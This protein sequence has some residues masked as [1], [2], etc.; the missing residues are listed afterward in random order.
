MN[1]KLLVLL[2]TFALFGACKHDAER[3]EGFGGQEIRIRYEVNQPGEVSRSGVTT[4][5]EGDVVHLYIAEREEEEAPVLPAQEDFNKMQCSADGSLRFEDGESHPYPENPI[6]LYAYYQKEMTEQAADVTAIPVQVYADQSA[7]GDEWRSDFLYAVAANGYRNQQEPITMTFK[8]QFSRVKFTITTDTPSEL[9]LS[10]LSAVEI[11][12]LVMDGK[13]NL[14]AGQLTLG[15]TEEMVTAGIPE[16][17]EEGV[18]AIVLPQTI[19]EGM[20]AFCFRVGEEEF[21]YEAPEGGVV[22]EAGKQYNYEICLNHYAGLS[23]KEILVNMTMENWNEVEMGTIMIS[24]GEEATVALEDVVEGVTITKADLHFGNA[25]VSDVPVAEGKMKFVF[26]RLVEDEVL[27]LKQACFYTA[28]G[29]SFNYY[30]NDKQ[31]IGN[32]ADVL[33]LPAPKIGDSWGEG[34]VFV[35]GEV[36]D[37]DAETGMLTTDTEGV[38]AYQGRMIAAK[39]LGAAKWTMS[40]TQEG[41]KNLIG[42]SDSLDG[43]ANLQKLEAFIASTGESVE[44]YPIYDALQVLDGWYVPSICEMFHI[45]TNQEILNAAFVVKGGDPLDK[46]NENYTSST[47]YAFYVDGRETEVKSTCVVGQ[48]TTGKNKVAPGDKAGFTVVARIVKAF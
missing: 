17:L 36:T 26:P 37:Y 35:V 14:Q 3:G 39:E 45:L 25:V 30:F 13:F 46:R 23:Q 32:G 21:V 9:D 12:N 22:F 8:H 31:L 4:I 47:E 11:Q 44:D 43:D 15:T 2:T 20:A 27:T 40:G 34:V 38:K 24:K 18:T 42:M 48:M 1:R 33:S 19:A 41:Y 16:V 7:E 28:G 29:E 10:A 5:S 6:D